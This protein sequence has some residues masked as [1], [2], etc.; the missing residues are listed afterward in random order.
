MTS[1][2]ISLV[3]LAVCVVL[4]AAA[5]AA[6]AAAPSRFLRL[7]LFLCGIGCCCSL[8]GPHCV[9]SIGWTGVCMADAYVLLFCVT[10]V[11]VTSS[12]VSS[13]SVSASSESSSSGS[14][15]SLAGACSGGLLLGGGG[16]LL[17]GGGNLL[18]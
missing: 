12:S 13:Y 16:L 2:T 3:S 10:S 15:C 14:V 17:S 8:A 7:V 18:F 1:F 4:F 9:P 11:S 5:T 6:A